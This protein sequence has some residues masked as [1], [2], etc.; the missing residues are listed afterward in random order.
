MTNKND[1]CYLLFPYLYG[2]SCVNQK[3][4]EQCQ[5]NSWSIEVP[6]GSYAIT[7]TARDEKNSAI[8]NLQANGQSVFYNKLLKSDTIRS[9]IYDVSVVNGMIKVTDN[10]S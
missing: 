1:Q 9:N 4:A 8:I 7:I 6:N 3:K 2:S 10:C 5:P